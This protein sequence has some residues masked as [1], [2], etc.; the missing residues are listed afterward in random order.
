V[1]W[2][3]QSNSEISGVQVDSQ[4]PIS[5]MWV[6][7]S[8]FSKSRVAKLILASYPPQRIYLLWAKVSFI[9]GG[10]SQ[11]FVRC[12]SLLYFKHLIFNQSSL[13][14]F[15]EVP[16]LVACLCY[17]L[18]VSP[19]CIC[20]DP[21]FWAC[22]LGHPTCKIPLVTLKTIIFHPLHQFHHSLACL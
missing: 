19:T 1:F 20:F 16:L 18:W 14:L 17:H 13:A 8:H 9:Q 15:F 5:G 2:P 3:L 4:V 10:L 11:S 6:S 21:F 22:F 7:S 12:L